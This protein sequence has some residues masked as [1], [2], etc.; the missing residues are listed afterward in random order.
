[1]VQILL[2]TLLL[3]LVAD[4]VEPWLIVGGLQLLVVLV[5]AVVHLVPVVVCPLVRQELLDK[6]LLVVVQET[7]LV[8]VVEVLAKLVTPTDLAPEVMVF[9]H[10]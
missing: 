4:M 10:L 9:H 3:H 7:M 1:M 8:L 5:V 6:D 2:S